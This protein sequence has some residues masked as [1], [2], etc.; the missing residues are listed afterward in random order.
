M[1]NIAYLYMADA[2]ENS[3]SSELVC[4]SDLLNK[5]SAPDWKRLSSRAW[6][7][8]LP[9][10]L[11]LSIL[12]SVSS[13]LALERG[14]QGPSV[15]D[16]QEQLQQAGFYQAPITQVYDFPTEDAVRRFQ[17]AHGLPVDGIVGVTTKQKLETSPT[18]QASNQAPRQ[19]NNNPQLPQL[20]TASTPF[21]TINDNNP[22]PP[23]PNTVKTKTTSS[24]SQLLQ[25]GDQGEKVKIL[26]QRLRVAG[27]YSSQATGVFNPITEEA[28]KRFQQAYKLDV[29]GIV[30]PATTSKLPPVGVS[31]KETPAIQTVN[32]DNLSTGN[33]GKAVRLLQQHL[34][35]AGYLNGTA[36]GYFGSQTA[37]AVSR[38]QAANYLTASGIA[39]PT[40]R[41]KLYS[42]INTASQSEF[43]I[44]EIQRR[45][46]EKGFYQGNLSGVMAEDTKRAIKKA[47]EFYGISLS[48]VRGGRF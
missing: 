27:F 43:S 23:K 5:A 46:Q 21:A 32:T 17:E 16:L 41:A 24:N 31:G 36:D 39:G 44:W 33:S 11:A 22:Q 2:Y 37:D 8:M 3:A 10:A 30:G 40:T 1:D 35:Q 20:S 14:D 28:V 9:L 25:L 42:L 12:S 4:L 45:L 6:K 29:D 26:Q 47:Q 38:F 18:Q 19:S 7:H 15:R 48:D 34:I 13:V